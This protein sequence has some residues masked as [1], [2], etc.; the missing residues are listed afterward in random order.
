MRGDRLI[1]IVLLLQTHGRMT[2]KELSE[3]LEVSER[4][5]HRDMDALSGTGIPVVAERGQKGG[6]S[7]LEDYRTDLTGLK[8]W[9]I[10][11]LF[12]SPSVH[13]LEDL[14]LTRITEEARNK[15]MASLPSS[16]RENGKDVWNRIHIDTSSWRKQKNK[17]A[18]LETIKEAVFQEIK[19][20][21]T[22]ER[23][24]GERDER[25]VEPLGLVAKGDLWYLIAAKENEDIRNYRV[26]RIH[27]TETLD[28]TFQRPLGFDL[29]E[30]WS[31]STQ[32]FIKRL[33]S[34]EAKVEVSPQLLSRLTFSGRFARVLEVGE[35]RGDE[36]IPVTLS[37]D[38]EEEAKAYLLGFADG[39]KV[40]EP[41]DLKQ[42]IV[43]MAE[44]TAS[45][46]RRME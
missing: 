19:L 46:Y 1:S 41:A 22:Y 18:S 3:K 26:S 8:E 23:A 4:T 7:L 11:A 43:K 29:T 17:T 45:F 2:A 35:R 14:G 12:V 32:S 25:I 40:I 16:Y 44:A 28:E 5:I 20:R 15:L 31:S 27:H 13:L 21:I 33:P 38:T 42:K 36:W 9:E 37:F 34:Y 10:R 24:D 30:Y 39:V 6:W